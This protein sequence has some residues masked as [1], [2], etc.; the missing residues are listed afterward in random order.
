[1]VPAILSLVKKYGTPLYV[2]D[3][4]VILKRLK[5]LQS[6]IN[7]RIFY[8]MKANYNPYILSLL[9]QQG[10]GVDAVSSGEVILARKVGFPKERIIYTANNMT[11]T[12]MK[13]V[14][15]EGVLFNIGSL[16]ELK[17]Y[18]RAFPKDKICLRW[19]VGIGAGH[20][21]Y[22]TTGGK[23][24]KFGILLENK[25]EA[26]SLV[27]KCGLRVVGVH[28]HAG[29][30]IPETVSMAK[31]MRALLQHIHKTE[32]PHLEFVDIGGGFKVPYKPREHRIDYHAFGLEAQAEMRLVS[33]EYDRPI[34]LYVEPGRVLVAESG[35]YLVE[36][37]T[38]KGKI[39]GTNGG[40]PQLIRPLLYDAHH[41][42][43]NV[44]HPKEQ[45][46]RYDIVGNICETG[47]YFAL[48]RKIPQVIPGDIL[49]VHTAGAYCYAMGGVYNLHP[50]PTEVL[51]MKNKTKV[52]RRKPDDDEFINGIL[53]ECGYRSGRE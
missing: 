6:S 21:W 35:T 44:S 43:T 4:K 15:Q 18:G 25:K 45:K 9:L 38:V 33:Q 27:K 50:M 30:G 11:A 17:R 8:A 20:H 29:S 34:H 13:R 46:K 42:I 39:V 52:I 51:V 26:L 49:A 22:T 16:D 12:E 19:N 14:H 24:S 47:D 37:V 7:A 2:Y 40:F 36:V 10:V 1:M 48:K 32:F 53:E 23:S 5:E 3:S 41:H 28:E 31:G